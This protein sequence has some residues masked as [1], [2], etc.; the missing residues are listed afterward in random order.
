L[1]R[2]NDPETGLVPPLKFIPLLEE[3][4]LIIQVG[5]W[6]LRHAVLDYQKL[7][8]KG[9]VCPRIAVNVSPL[10]LRQK[11]F[12]NSLG[13]VIGLG[14]GQAHGLDL[15]I[16]ESVIMENI[17]SNIGQL[18]A[19]QAMG[20]NIAIDDFGTGYSSLAYISKLP[21]NTL[22]IDRS[23][24]KSMA[25]SVED[26]NIVS[27]IIALAHSLKLKVVAEGVETQD[28]YDA[29]RRLQCDEMQGYLVSVPLPIE[30]M[31]ALLRRLPG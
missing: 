28:Q 22:K 27:T 25:H 20:V 5:A 14:T 13:A 6:A 2:W 3:T 10:Q 18:R 4:G 30:D 8:S 23:F 9:L 15:E 11:D 21:V 7:S 1:I 16:T 29:L 17:E 31:E 24:V 26:M 12:A 19:I